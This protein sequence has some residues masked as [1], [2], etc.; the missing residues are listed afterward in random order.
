MDSLILTS[1]IPEGEKLI[2]EWKEFLVKN[3][4]SNDQI[5]IHFDKKTPL[6]TNDDGL[7]FRIDFVNDRENYNKFKKSIHQEPLARALG[8]GS[9][10]LRLLDLSAGLAIDSV[11]LMQ[12][13]FQVVAVERNPLIYL[14]LK[15]AL[16]ESRNF[17]NLE[18]IYADS[19]DYIQDLQFDQFDVGYFDPMFEEKKKS[20]LAKQ[21]MRFFKGL[22]GA[23]LD[24]EKV[25]S[26]VIEKKIFK[27]F[28]VKRSLKATA[29]GNPQGSIQGK[30]I[31]YDIYGG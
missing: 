2:F 31:R 6:I 13:G 17:K 22:V 26:E 4:K 25:V 9:K 27:R 23:D 14:C 5:S 18:F 7:K 21:E 10:G 8:A 29:F 20:A 28:V 16:A 15:A 19:L 11:F 1:E 24:A 12:L 3:F 30:I